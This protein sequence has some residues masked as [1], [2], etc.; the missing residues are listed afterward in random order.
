LKEKTKELTCEQFARKPRVNTKE[1][2]LLQ[3]THN[4][5]KL[6]IGK[7][8]VATPLW[9]ECEDETHTIEMGT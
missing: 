6:S 1:F 2:H 9:E 3:K 5:K 8:A 4:L 7:R